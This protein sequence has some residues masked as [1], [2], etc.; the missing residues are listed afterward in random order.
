MSQES[1]SVSQTARLLG[2]SSPTVRRMVADGELVGFRTPGGHLRITR[3]SVE[4]VRTSSQEKRSAAGAS[5]VLRIRRERVEE[6]ALEAQELRAERVIEKLR[7]EREE[8]RA[9]LEAEAEAQEHQA[10]REAEA[11]RLRLERVRIQQESERE[12]HEAER[13]LQ[14]FRTRWLQ[15]A[16]EFVQEFRFRLHYP[17]LSPRQRREILNACEAEIA[18]RQLA[19]GPLMKAIIERTV[20][21][22][23]EPWEKMQ[24]IVELRANAT[25]VALWKLPGGA[26]EQ[27]N[28]QAAS[29]IRHSLEK[30][31]AS[32]TDCEFRAAAEEA[33][34]RLCQAIEKRKLVEQVTD[35]A[36]RQLP[37]LEATD[38]DKN[39]LRQECVEALAELPDDISKSEAQK[40]VQ[41]LIEQATEDIEDR[42]A[43]EEHHRR[44]PQL[45]ATGLNEVDSYLRNLKEADEIAA[46]VYWD[47]ERKADLEEAVR[48]ELEAELTGDESSKEVRQLVREIID[49][50]FG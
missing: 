22:T 49:D 46:Q 8:E 24:R 7:R 15:E 50:E 28:A 3:E 27:E 20:N 13:K 33:I 23:I 4:A 1:Y 2:I 6:L 14:A 12:R 47:S 21:A 37:W 43:E 17:W 44:K 40:Y 36:V 39:S 38:A 34:T 19:D 41:G 11:A 42:K 10:D 48:D 9:E 5:P 45:I 31:P 18:N 16:E 30:L 26:T 35:W 32:A 29:L 25:R